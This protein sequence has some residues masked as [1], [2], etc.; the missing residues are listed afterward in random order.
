MTCVRPALTRKPTRG[1]AWSCGAC[2]RAQE[3][4]LEARH[5][6]VLPEPGTEEEEE[7][8]EEDPEAPI[9]GLARI[10]SNDASVMQ[11]ASENHPEDALAKLWPWRY[12]GIHCRV[13]DVLQFDDRAIY[14]RAVSRLGL[15]HEAIV[16]P[17]PGQPVEYVKPLEIKR[18]PAKNGKKD[19]K[20]SKE[21]LATIEAD[22]VERANRPKWVQDEPPGW[23]S[24]GED[25]DDLG[26]NETCTLLFAISEEPLP[27]ANGVPTRTRE[28]I[29]DE[30]E[31]RIRQLAKEWGLA[32]PVHPGTPGYMPRAY[33][34]KEIV[35]TNFLDEALGLLYI[36]QLNIPRALRALREAHGPV[37]LGEPDF[38]KEE[39][40]KFED[41]VM[42][43]G[44]DLRTVKK[45]VKT[46]PYGDIVRFF[47][48]WK[49]TERGQQVWGKSE[50]RSRVRKKAETLWPEIADEEDD[51]AF[52][53]DK[54]V[55][56]KR[57][58]QCKFCD[59]RHSRQWRRAPNVQP[60]VVVLADPKGSAKDKSN[61][62]VVSLCE[63]CAGLWRKYAMRYEDPEEFAKAIIQAGGRA[64]KRKIDEET[65]REC[66]MANEFAGIVS[67]PLAAQ[68]AAMI[69]IT[70]TVLPATDKKRL[71]DKD[72]MSASPGPDSL[73]KKKEILAPPPPPPREPTPPII[74]AQP[75][76]RELPCSI[77]TEIQVEGDV[78]CVCTSC[79]LTV[80]KR[81]YGI[82]EQNNTP[83]WVCETCMNDK[84]NQA[85]LVSTL[86][87]LFRDMLIVE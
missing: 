69:G 48:T 21:Q 22:K 51:S 28:Q 45:N 53:N 10:E 43:H 61:Q 30:Y 65:L 23:R 11:T 14:P 33:E 3:K 85:S 46:K 42:K 15:K 57:K 79:K 77:C 25:V 52:D 67:S 8:L 24:R 78:L 62:L 73:P 82:N 13:E 6:A 49:K 39:L 16:L 2:S 83:R 56:K 58:F 59:T 68:A 5:T 34:P 70:V 41:A 1:F 18:K 29:V 47:Y 17:W 32:R 31:A 60:G 27:S 44:S 36:Y 71:K 74:P 40:K 80:H 76:W 9:N 37:D 75:K 84:N 50:G 55:S 12:L 7:I 54:A 66:V 19:S 20:L 86:P 81:C 26:E 38:T 72:S 4:K 35:P 63:R 64:W 87:N